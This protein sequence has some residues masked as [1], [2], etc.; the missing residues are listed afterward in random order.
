MEVINQA[1]DKFMKLCDDID[2]KVDAWQ[3]GI[4]IQ[5]IADKANTRS[6]FVLVAV[7]VL[8]TILCWFGMGDSLFITLVGFVM[9]AY[10]SILA[11]ETKETEDDKQWL[12]YWVVFTFF[13]LLEFCLDMV[14]YV[15]PPYFV[16]KLLFLMWCFMPA[17]RGATIVYE[18]VIRPAV[19]MCLQPSSA[20]GVG[21]KVD[22]SLHDAAEKLK[23]HTPKLD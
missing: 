5:N 9:P 11:I 23:Q 15:F 13:H 16:C 10:W 22:S 19:G 1:K 7:A 20:S 14:L 3:H 8:M 6:S 12:T 4:H 18:K 17:T 2:Q 21:A